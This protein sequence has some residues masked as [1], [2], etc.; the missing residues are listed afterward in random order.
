M[1]NHI[2]HAKGIGFCHDPSLPLLQQQEALQ[3][4]LTHSELEK[5]EQFLETTAGLF[6]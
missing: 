4:N 5:I 6:D 2:C 3:L 1:A